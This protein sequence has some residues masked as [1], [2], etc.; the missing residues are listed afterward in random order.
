MATRYEE[1]ELKREQEFV[2]RRIY[3]L[4]EKQNLS[5]RELSLSLGLSPGYITKLENKKGFPSL[6][7]LFFIC[8][9]FKI[10]PAEFFSEI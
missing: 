4:R 6:P 8:E 3:Q 9:Y 2:K 5:A 10:T 1:W 7:V